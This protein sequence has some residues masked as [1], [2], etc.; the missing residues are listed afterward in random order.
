MQNQLIRVQKAYQKNTDIVY[1][2]HSLDPENDTKEVLK[3]YA[4]RLG[5]DTKTWYFVRGTEEETYRMAGEGGYFISAKED[6]NAPGGIDHSGGFILVDKAGHIRGYYEGTDEK[7]VD[8]LIE[9]LKI[10]QKQY[11]KNEGA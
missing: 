1:L 11:E 8:K 6:E 2:S 3:N 5:A 4:E 10:L 7:D 9:D